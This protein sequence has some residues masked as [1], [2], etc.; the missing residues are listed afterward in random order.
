MRMTSS[1]GTPVTI[2]FTDTAGLASNTAAALPVDW[3]EIVSDM[4]LTL[5]EED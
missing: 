2:Q 5:G 4:H 1:S 3:H